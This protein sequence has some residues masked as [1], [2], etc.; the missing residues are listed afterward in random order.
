MADLWEWQVCA[1][2]NPFD[3][4]GSHEDPLPVLVPVL[5]DILPYTGP[6]YFT[7]PWELLIPFNEYEQDDI[8]IILLLKCFFK[9][10]YRIIEK[11][12]LLNRLRTIQAI[13]VRHLVDEEACIL[14]DFLKQL[15][16]LFF[17]LVNR[18]LLIAPFLVHYNLSL[19]H[20][21]DI[22]CNNIHC[23]LFLIRVTLLVCH[24]IDIFL[25]FSL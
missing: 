5:F 6:L 23:L 19:V 12:N 8:C 25:D 9:G 13:L 17:R 15:V 1:W 7:D 10:F 16:S 20:I 21:S 22:T 3:I 24:L 2:D 4:Y 18:L 11:C 14:V